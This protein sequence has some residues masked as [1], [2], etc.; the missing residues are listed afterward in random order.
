MYQ[1]KGPR[2]TE[3]RIRRAAA[4]CYRCHGRKVRCDAS[5]LGYP[6]TNCVLDG[7]TDCT[8]RPNATA[9]FKNLKQSQRR[10]TA[11][12]LA[13]PIED[14]QKTFNASGEPCEATPQSAVLP[15]VT[16]LPGLLESPDHTETTFEHESDASTQILDPL[17]VSSPRMRLSSV[18]TSFSGQPFLDLNALS[19]LPMSDVHILVTGGCLDMPPKVAMDVFIMK[20]FLLVHPSVPILDEVEFWNAYLQPEDSVYAPKISLFVF[21][22]LLLSSCAV[23]ILRPFCGPAISG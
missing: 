3:K 14:E 10:N 6:C 23:C 13:R 7:R 17:P 4:A 12:R 2:P 5:I 16:G 11:E 8:L 22:A 19:L 20:Y 1:T 15:P 18:G 21:Q 9:R